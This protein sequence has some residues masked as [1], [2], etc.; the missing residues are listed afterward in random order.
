MK[1]L[2]ETLDA[3]EGLSFG[4]Y[5]D[6]W[7][8]ADSLRTRVEDAEL[9]AKGAIALGAERTLE[10]EQAKARIAELEAEVARLDPAYVKGLQARF[11][12][13]SARIA[14]LEAEL[15]KAEV[16]TTPEK[17]NA[18]LDAAR[19]AGTEAALR[20]AIAYVRGWHNGHWYGN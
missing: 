14:E 6:L 18:M 20:W 19:Q 17:L 10:L 2:R 5:R 9:L 7:M 8:E 3:F 16:R 15:E 1:A 13:Q 4:E 12:D 11:A